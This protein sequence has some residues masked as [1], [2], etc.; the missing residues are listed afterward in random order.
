M[1]TQTLS[2]SANVQS[3]ASKDELARTEAKFRA[4]MRRRRAVVIL[5]RLAILVAVLGGWELGARTGL[6]DPFF[7]ASPSGIAD[8]IWIWITE[9]TSQGPLSEQIIVTLEETALGF[10]IGA[11]G[12]VICGILL[13]RN[14][15]LADVFSIYIK[16]A[17]SIPRV[18]LGSIFIIALGLGMAS[19][20]A[21]AVVMVFFV[22]FANAF[23]GVREADRALIANA[24]ILGASRS[25]ITRT[26]IVPS[27]MSWILASLHV[28]FGF[29]LVGAVVGEF[30][31]AKKGVGLMISTAQGTFN[32]NGV[33]AAMVILAVLALVVEYIITLIEN[34][35]VKW[36]P[37]ALSEQGS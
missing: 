32:A 22:V 28:S 31:G 35:L 37:Q 24:Q 5:V 33:F 23:Q 34:H 8:Q 25:Q 1:T 36:R 9:G 30:L 20:V 13:G 10:L 14:K 12:G 19:K 29:A 6:I 21:L 3:S 16:I 15:F 17:N 2:A 27:A 26:V 7:F 11:V 18:V 4:A